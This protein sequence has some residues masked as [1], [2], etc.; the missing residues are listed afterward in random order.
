M[1]SSSNTPTTTN[2]NNNNNNNNNKTIAALKQVS[3][4][5]SGNLQILQSYQIMSAIFSSDKKKLE[6][7]LG[8]DVALQAIK[9]KMNILFYTFGGVQGQLKLRL[10]VPGFE[11]LGIECFK[12]NYT[13]VATRL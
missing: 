4:I 8:S 3:F 6:L 11:Q 7:I 5:Q 10:I 12:C 2:N 9:E 1:N 13:K